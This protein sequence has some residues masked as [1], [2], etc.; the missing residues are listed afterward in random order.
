MEAGEQVSLLLVERSSEKK[1]MKPETFGNNH[2]IA[3]SLT[4]FTLIKLK[5]QL[6]QGNSGNF[7]SLF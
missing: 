5:F 2:F 7:C 4:V 1:R 3:I 6:L